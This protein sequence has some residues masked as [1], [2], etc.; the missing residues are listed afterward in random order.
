MGCLRLVGS[1]KLL[2]SFAE[3]G[4]FDRALLQKR[5]IIVRS[6]LIVATLYHESKVGLFYKSRANASNVFSFIGLF[7]KRDL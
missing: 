3:S 6:L 1:F 7:C 2:V 4:L 5:P